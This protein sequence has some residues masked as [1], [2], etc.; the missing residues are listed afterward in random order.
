MK[1]HASPVSLARDA[2]PITIHLP[3]R[4]AK[5]AEKFANENGNTVTGVVIEALDFFLRGQNED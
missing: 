4:L 1:D 2:Q 3:C 5:R